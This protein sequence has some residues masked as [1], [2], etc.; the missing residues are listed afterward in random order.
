LLDEITV[1]AEHRVKH[2]LFEYRIRRVPD[3]NQITLQLHHVV[4]EPDL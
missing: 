1:R 2:A 3:E 4:I